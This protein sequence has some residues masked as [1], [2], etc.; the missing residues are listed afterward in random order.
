MKRTFGAL[1]LLAGL[2]GCVTIGNDPYRQTRLPD[3]KTV[4]GP[5]T[6]SPNLVAM[7][8]P[9]GTMPQ[10]TIPQGTMSHATLPTAL[11]G[12]IPSDMPGNSPRYTDW[13]AHPGHATAGAVSPATLPTPSSLPN[14]LIARGPVPTSLQPVA[15]PDLRPVPPPGASLPPASAGVPQMPANLLTATTPAEPKPDLQTTAFATAASAT[16]THSVTRTETKLPEIVNGPNQAETVKTPAKT[17]KKDESPAVSGNVPLANKGA[18]PLVRLVN[19]K[20]I[21]LNFEVAD[22]GSSGLS[23]VELWYTQDGKEWKKHQAPTHAK[24]YVVE[25]DEEG[26]YG[27]TLLARSGIGLGMEPPAV[28]D[29]P[30]V[31]VIVD[32]SAPEVQLTEVTPIT[33]GKEQE[34]SIKWSAADKNLG[35]GPVTLSYAESED[36]PWQVIAANLECNGQF[37]WKAPVGIPAK[38]YIKAEATDLAGNIGR[39]TTP[40]PLLMDS[41][42][43]KVSIVNVEANNGR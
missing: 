31:W 2:T 17:A 7:T 4:A 42:L 40:K 19:T 9:P 21:T 28:G 22:V 5:G 12:S 32:L 41:S 1:V 34:V 38:V 25:V 13:Q 3:P 36:G 15:V 35:R 14:T 10:G 18:M 30:Q 26:M 37:H 8:T 27:F 16:A 11:P 23:A 24:S 6:L 29:Q 39:A 43:P 20:R 33:K